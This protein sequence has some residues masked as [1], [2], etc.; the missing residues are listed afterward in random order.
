MLGG[1]DGIGR[2]LHTALHPT[3]AS[4]PTL[5]EAW[6]TRTAASIVATVEG[7]RA[8]WQAWHVRAEAQRRARAASIPTAQLDAAVERLVATALGE[9]SLPLAVSAEAI[10]EPA[11]LQRVDGQSVYTVAGAELF[12]SPRILAAEQRL[13]DAAGR[14]DGR[15]VTRPPSRSLYWRRRRTGSS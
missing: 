12:T 8:T 13:V 5:D 15:T 10:A 11:A 9:H 14:H 2:M 3:R 6:F 1:P 4:V 7:S